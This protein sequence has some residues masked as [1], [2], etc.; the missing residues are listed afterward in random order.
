MNGKRGGFTIVEIMVALALV[1]IL[2]NIMY[3]LS[4]QQHNTPSIQERLT[5]QRNA[6]K[7]LIDL[8]RDLR[9]SDGAIATVTLTAGVNQL[10]LNLPLS[11]TAS[12]TVVY[13]I[14]VPRGT[15]TRSINAQTPVP[16]TS[17]INSVG[18][19]VNADDATVTV[20]ADYPG[21]R[22]VLPAASRYS[23]STR[24]AWRNE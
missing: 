9:E 13:R 18:I 16:I 21:T 24:I 15:L 17:G 12:D 10:Q 2:L 20:T 1:G 14:T 6:H 22:F 23:E 4:F 19:A 3:R 7:A 11:N 5:M 8:E